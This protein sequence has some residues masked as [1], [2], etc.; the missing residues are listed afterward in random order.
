MISEELRGKINDCIKEYE[1]CGPVF[2]QLLELIQVPKQEIV[3]VEFGQVLKEINNIQVL[4][5]ARKK[6]TLMVYKDYIS[7][8]LA[9]VKIQDLKSVLVLPSPNKAKPHW[10]LV[11][12]SGIGPELVTETIGLGLDLSSKE[13]VINTLTSISAIRKLGINM[14]CETVFVS[15]GNSRKLS[16]VEAYLKNKDG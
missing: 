14:P 2:N 4:Y 5:P 8:G 10:S 12:T 6:T 9:W 7:V 3:K 11:M 15:R 1:P 16:F 13:D